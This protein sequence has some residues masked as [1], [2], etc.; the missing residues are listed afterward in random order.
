MTEME[1]LW[2]EAGSPEYEIVCPTG[3]RAVLP[4][5]PYMQEYKRQI[6]E[7]LVEEGDLTALQAE[8]MM[9]TTLEPVQKHAAEHSVSVADCEWC[10]SATAAVSGRRDP[11]V[12]VDGNVSSCMVVSEELNL[13][14]L[15]EKGSEEGEQPELWGWQVLVGDGPNELTCGRAVG[16]GSRDRAKFDALTWVKSFIGQIDQKLHVLVYRT[17]IPK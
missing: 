16:E 15:V 14:V 7:W 13:L 17:P 2:H 8:C 12:W 11:F 5:A 4:A 1:Q 10:Q 9:R 6:L 3:Q